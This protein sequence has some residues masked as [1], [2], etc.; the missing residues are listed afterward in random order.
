MNPLFNVYVTQN[1]TIDT[2]DILAKLEEITDIQSRLLQDQSNLL[3]SQSNILTILENQNTAM[4]TNTEVL[5][6]IRDVQVSQNNTLAAV[7]TAVSNEAE[8]VR[9]GFERLE[10]RLAE[11]GV[12]NAELESIKTEAMAHL[13]ALEDIGETVTEIYTPE[14]ETPTG[15]LPS[16]GTPT[17]EPSTGGDLPV[18]G[19]NPPAEPVTEPTT[20]TEAPSGEG[21]TGVQ[22]GTGGEPNGDGSSVGGGQNSPNNF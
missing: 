11:L 3:E 5:G 2:S 8:Q 1:Q 4:S 19:G 15:G 6:Q 13:E 20:G 10:S 16:G 17:T 21:E 14:S 22:S 18:Q 12:S 9:I 7:G